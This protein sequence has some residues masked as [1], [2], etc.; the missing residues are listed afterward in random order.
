[1]AHDALTPLAPPVARTAAESTGLV[2]VSTDDPGLSRRRRGSG[3]IYRDA[4]GAPV[5]DA[6]IIARIHSLAIPPAWKDVW[7]CQDPL[8][9]VQAVGQDERGRRQYRYHPQFRE[10]REAA[11]FDHLVAFAEALP[12]LRAQVDRDL[13]LPGLPREKVLATVVRLLETTMIRIG[14][15]DYA[16]TNKSYGLTTLL[17]RHVSVQ[18][19]DLRFHFKGKSGKT[20]RLQVKDRRVAKIVR[21]CQDL[22]GQNLFQYIEEDGERQHVTSTDVNRYL[23]AVTDRDITA[24]DFRTWTGTVLAAV[25]ISEFDGVEAPAERK[26]TL[27]LAIRRVAEQLGNTPAICRRC[28]VHPDIQAAYLESG[29]ALAAT[30]D[31][32]AHPEAGPTHLTPEEA[33]VLDFLR[34]D[35]TASREP[36]GQKR[37]ARGAQPPGARTNSGRS[38]AAVTTCLPD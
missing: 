28:Y 13:R 24:K 2:Y 16:R 21:T 9:H 6:R 3:F 10:V 35:A 12:D 37:P 17:N 5:S 23:K 19:S 29:V 26:K 20:W 15:A 27:A 4:S 7:I 1:M 30:G 31:S 33:M 14:N 25:A 11:K 22:P 36:S 32:L 38:P 18:G 8:G 34:S